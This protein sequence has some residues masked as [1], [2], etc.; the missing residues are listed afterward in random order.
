[1]VGLRRR[2]GE[3]GR[4]EDDEDDYS[5]PSFQ[6]GGVFI[7]VQG[8]ASWA[9][10][11]SV[12]TGEHLVFRKISLRPQ[13]TAGFLQPWKWA[14]CEVTSVLPERVGEAEGGLLPVPPKAIREAMGS[15]CHFS[16]ANSSLQ[17]LLSHRTQERQGAYS[18]FVSERNLDHQYCLLNLCP[19]RGK[20][21]EMLGWDPAVKQSGEHVLLSW[22]GKE[23]TISRLKWKKKGDFRLLH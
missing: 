10:L 3:G 21:F 11:G 18:S 20:S 9:S 15:A 16:F 1:M 4:N 6:M 7:A 14:E 17:G 23:K 22:E 5:T 12:F 2:M 13:N 8:T 19:E